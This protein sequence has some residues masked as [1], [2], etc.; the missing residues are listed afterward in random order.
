MEYSRFE[1]LI[2]SS[3]FFRRNR[4]VHNMEEPTCSYSLS[5]RCTSSSY[6]TYLSCACSGSYYATACGCLPCP[7]NSANDTHLIDR[8]SCDAGL[9][10]EHGH[11]ETCPAYQYS[12]ANSTA[13]TQ[14]PNGASSETGSDHFPASHSGALYGGRGM[15]EV[16]RLETTC[17]VSVSVPHVLRVLQ[18][19][20]LLLT[21]LC[22]SVTG[23]P[24]GTL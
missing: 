5:T 3:I 6:Y 18:T 17:S 21:T 16:W 8:C 1:L 9:Y 7:A 12:A 13:C 15:Q 24:C 11:C 20:P 4:R 10:W 2:N 22:A 14:F 19:V 23:V